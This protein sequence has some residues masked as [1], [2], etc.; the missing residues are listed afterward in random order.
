MMLATASNSF[1]A[2]SRLPATAYLFCI[3]PPPSATPSSSGGRVVGGDLSR[4]QLAAP[5]NLLTPG[6]TRIGSY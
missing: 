3:T 2:A 1:A 6:I 4:R 5:S